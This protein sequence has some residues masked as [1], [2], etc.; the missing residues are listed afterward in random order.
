MKKSVAF[1]SAAFVLL[2]LA[3]VC[4][5]SADD[6]SVKRTVDFSATVN[7]M[8]SGPTSFLGKTGV[9][10]K[11]QSASIGK[12][13]TITARATIVDSNGN[14]LDRLGVTTAGPVS[15]SFIAAYIPAGQTQYVSYTTS[16]SKATITSNPSQTQAANDSGG[17]F[18]TNAVGDY[19]YTFHTKAPTT[20]DPTVTH[21]IGVSAQRDL[22][23]YG[24][25]DEWS[26][27]SNDVFT[28]VPNGSPVTV[29]RSLVT[30]AACN[31]CHDPL[32]GHGGSRLKV[33]L[34]IMCHTPQTINADTLLTQDM[35]VL[36]HKIHMGSSLPSVKAGTPYRIWHRGQWSDFSTVVFPQD[37]RNCT[38]CHSSAAG[39]PNAW[40]TTPGR[41]A[42][43]SCH[44]DVNF[45]TGLNHL[46]LPQVDDSQCSSCHIQKGEL[47]FDASIVGAH[48]IPNYSTSLPGLVLKIVKV[49]GTAPG[50]SPTVTFSVAD[51]SNNAVDI[52][53]ITQIRVVLSGQNVDYQTGTNGIRFSEDPSKTPGSVGV[54]TYTMTNKLPATATGSYTISV[55]ARN[56]VTLL[57]NTTASQTA[58][59][60]AVPVEYYFTVDQSPVVPRRQ[61][62]STA[63]CSACH[64]DLTFVHTGI[65]NN[66]QECVI[67]HNPTLSDGT[68]GQSVSFATQ[69]HSIHRGDNLANPYTL[70]TTNYQSVRFP[71]D[72]RDCTACHLDSTYMVENVGAKAAVASP[73]GFTKTTPPISAACQGCHD[74]IGTASHALANTTILGESCTACHSAGMEFSVDRVHQRIF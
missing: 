22:S 58:I 40:K 3:F 37:V 15:M 24:T 42:C 54:Y 67:C 31:Q 29:T 4:T 5:A 1:A 47:D 18:T 51:K 33:E 35:K 52:S 56:T 66:T 61:V 23:A 65:R 63:K 34:C 17:T 55:E 26:E 70:G 10:V 64:K 69:I 7:P 11:I 28:F 62:V 16:V 39:Q 49:T 21:S 20:F 36:I 19:T 60:S 71:G 74:D 27:T 9:V 14:P 44:D 46:N 38:T 41:D 57:P 2:L 6:R 53:K 25:F 32:I 48:V 30:T 50:S 43:G 12:D 45:A 13:G 73:G 59:D 8:M 72:L 68:S